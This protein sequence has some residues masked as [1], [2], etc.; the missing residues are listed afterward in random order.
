MNKEKNYSG[1]IG[2]NANKKK[3]EEN[4]NFFKENTPIYNSTCTKVILQM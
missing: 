2:N 4:V 1:L 3:V